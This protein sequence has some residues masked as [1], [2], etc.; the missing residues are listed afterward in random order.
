MKR[1]IYIFALIISASFAACDNN[2]NEVSKELQT[3]AIGELFEPNE[4]NLDF[5]NF[6][7]A[8]G[9]AMKENKQFRKLIKREALSKFDGDYDILLRYVADK[10]IEQEGNSVQLRSSFNVKDLLEGSYNSINSLNNANLRSGSSESIIEELIAKYP[11]LQITVPIHA[12]DWDDENDIPIVT[13]VPLEFEDGVTQ[14]VTGY[15]PDGSIT[16]LNA[17]TPPNQTVIVISENE[18]VVSKPMDPLRPLEPGVPIVDMY[19]DSLPPL[20]PIDL[21]A[22]QTGEG[23]ALSWKKNQTPHP[24]TIVGYHIYRKSASDANFILRAVNNGVNNTVYVDQTTLAGATYSYYITAYNGAGSSDASNTVL[25]TGT[26]RPSALSSFEV[27]QNTINQIE[28]RWTTENNQYIQ[29]TRLAKNVVGITN[30]YQSIGEFN[31]NTYDYFD[32][33]VILGEKVIY[34]AYIYTETGY[35]NPKYDFVKVPYRDPSKKSQ[36]RIKQIH[37]NGSV[38]SWLRGSP[39]FCIKVL[40]VDKDNKSYEIQSQIYCDFEGSIFGWDETQN[41]DIFVMDWKPDVWYDKLTFYVIED[42]HNDDTK[43][44]LKAEINYKTTAN[45]LSVATTTGVE[46]SF[47]HDGEKI[48]Y[49]YLDYFDEPDI[50]I[51]FPNYGFTMKFGKE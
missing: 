22:L 12:E 34:R 19:R 38:E 17:I 49:G 39:E 26:G 44:T 32:N 29:G 14:L 33:N 15:N 20:S 36:V 2:E 51:E 48:G 47:S 9:N 28:V 18:R 43:I 42:D 3:E 23:V 24:A 11:D 5:K 1:I 30:G 31:S 35:S 7:L 41:F 16:T 50:K 13:F 46:Y 27:K 45:D 4:Y 21:T 10:S 25:V 6:A 8:V 37:C 40:G